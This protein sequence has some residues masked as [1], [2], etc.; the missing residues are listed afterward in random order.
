VFLSPQGVRILIEQILTD[1]FQ[2]RGEYSSTSTFCFP[3]PALIHCL[4]GKA[5]YE[6]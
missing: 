2:N 1:L 3:T 5:I 4:Q 6:V